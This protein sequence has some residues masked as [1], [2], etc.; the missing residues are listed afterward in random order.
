[1]SSSGRLAEINPL[2]YRGYYYDNETGFYYL[3]SRYYDPANR[4]FIN[5][6]SLASTGQGFLG[7]NMFAYCN[8]CPTIYE[9]PSGHALRSNLALICDGGS[10]KTEPRYI[11][12]QDL[13]GIAPTP[14]GHSNVGNAGCGAVATYNALQ[15]LNSGTSLNSIISY[16]QSNNKM[17]LNGHLGL[18][19]SSVIDYFLSEGYSVLSC[20]Y[21]MEYSVKTAETVNSLSQ[22]ADASILWYVYVSDS[23]VGAHF[24]EYHRDGGRICGI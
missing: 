24:F 10:G 15:T 6:D 23:G 11:S 14:F 2:R 19:P 16:Y 3:Q 1:M 9:D 20:E 12:D 17:N 21:T 4:R 22:S 8:N 5:A 18:M 13:P 7:T